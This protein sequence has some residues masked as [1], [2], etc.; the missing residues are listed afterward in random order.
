MYKL[1]ASALM[2]RLGLN[3]GN[4]PTLPA[5]PLTRLRAPPSLLDIRI[6]AEKESHPCR[7]EFGRFTVTTHLRLFPLSLQRLS[8]N[9]PSPLRFHPLSCKHYCPAIASGLADK[10]CVFMGIS[11]ALAFF[12]MNSR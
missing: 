6:P 7:L 3:R 4:N 1:P 9:L 10:S 8:R 12:D 5:S 11:G 2:R